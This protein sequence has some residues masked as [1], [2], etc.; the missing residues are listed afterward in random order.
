MSALRCS[1]PFSLLRAL[2]VRLLP[3]HE[4]AGALEE[5]IAKL[6]AEVIVLKHQEAEPLPWW[7][8][9]TGTFENDAMFDDAMSLGAEY[10]RRDEY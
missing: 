4:P 5:R 8:A 2:W 9:V 10:R 7:E 3:L 6:E 1:N